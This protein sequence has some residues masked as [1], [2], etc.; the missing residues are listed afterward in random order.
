MRVVLNQSVGFMQF[1]VSLGAGAVI[2]WL[3][4]ELVPAQRSYVSSSK[5]MENSLFAASTEWFQVLVTNLP[6][7][8]LGICSIGG[9]AFAVAQTRFGQ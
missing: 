2:Y 9:L 3:V 4:Q 7:I 8:L 6:I 5:A 1:F